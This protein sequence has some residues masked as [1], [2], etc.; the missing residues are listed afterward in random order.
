MV[1]LFKYTDVPVRI[2]KTLLANWAVPDFT[3]A[4]GVAQ[5]SY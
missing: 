4:T 5:A 1:H 3:R 2:A